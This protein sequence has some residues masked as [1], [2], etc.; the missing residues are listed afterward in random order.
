VGESLIKLRINQSIN[1]FYL[2]GVHPVALFTYTTVHEHII[3]TIYIC[4]PRRSLGRYSSLADSDH[5][6][7]FICNPAKPRKPAILSVTNHQQNLSDSTCRSLSHVQHLFINVYKTT[8]VL[9]S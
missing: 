7:K 3:Y 5:G 9:K 6:V 4:N 2:C 1:K 8:T